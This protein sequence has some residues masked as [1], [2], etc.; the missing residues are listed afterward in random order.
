MLTSQEIEE[1]LNGTDLEEHIVALEFDYMTNDIYKI[2]KY[3]TKEN[4][5]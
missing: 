4:K 5:L 2:K 3:Q 1:F